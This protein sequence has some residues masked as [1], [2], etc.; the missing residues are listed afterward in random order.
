[1]R[2]C[3]KAWK[4]A[5]KL[6]LCGNAFRYHP[7]HKE[8][9]KVVDKCIRKHC[10]DRFINT[11]GDLLLNNVRNQNLCPRLR[12]QDNNQTSSSDYWHCIKYSSLCWW[13]FS[14]SIK[15]FS[16]WLVPNF[17]LMLGPIQLLYGLY[18]PCSEWQTPSKAKG[19]RTAK[20]VDTQVKVLKYVLAWSNGHGW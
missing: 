8:V 17:L 2:Q 15:V 13:L 10:V 12:W 11:Y 19:T 1:M 5:V 4:D 9:A 14:H 18:C 20:H 3:W 7:T 16:R 6:V